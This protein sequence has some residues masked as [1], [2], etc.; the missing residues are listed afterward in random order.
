MR[1]KIHR[2]QPLVPTIKVHFKTCLVYTE[3]HQR[4][5][6]WEYACP[7]CREE[8]LKACQE[9]YGHKFPSE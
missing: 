4:P 3:E 5:K 9:E 2:D 1:C 7:I 8:H 6:R